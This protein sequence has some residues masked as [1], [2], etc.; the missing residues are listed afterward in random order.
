MRYLLSLTFLLAACG[1]LN[2]G[3]TNA[4]GTPKTPIDAMQAI[5]EVGDAALITYGSQWLK[6]HV[7]GLVEQLDADGNGRL[8][9][10]E[11]ESQV[12]LN[13]PGSLTTLLV[14]LVELHEAQKA[15]KAAGLSV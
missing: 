14:I 12:D 10:A 5:R 13:S 4:D 3:S 15:R 8:S 1:V 6:E 7:P 11:I 2:L 9:L